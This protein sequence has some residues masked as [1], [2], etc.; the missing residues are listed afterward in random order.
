MVTGFGMAVIAISGGLLGLIYVYLS[1]RVS[2][3]RI[4]HQIGIGHGG[5]HELEQAIRT[6]GNFME[7]VPLAL[8]LLIAAQLL[9]AHPW[10]ILVGSVALVVGRILHAVGLTRTGGRTHARTIGIVLTYGV[11]ALMALTCIAYGILRLQ[12]YMRV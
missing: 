9:S 8:V 11:I 1:L 2:R 10:L 5:V 12:L 3:L 6:H 7:Y 4:M